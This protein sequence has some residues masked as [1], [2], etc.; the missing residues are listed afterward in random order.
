MKKD[1]LNLFSI[2]LDPA[3]YQKV[4]LIRWKVSTLL[5]WTNKSRYNK[6][7]KWLKFNQCNERTCTRKIGYQFN[8][9]SNVSSLHS[10]K[11]EERERERGIKWILP[12]DFI[13]AS[14]SLKLDVA[15]LSNNYN[16]L[17]FLM[18]LSRALEDLLD[19]VDLTKSPLIYVCFH[20][21]F[22]LG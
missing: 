11:S 12:S 7:P 21:V 18:I 17:F 16:L 3:F 9:H 6:I 4:N 15:L 14:I 8:L 19:L 5:G 20:A 22:R 10:W 2:I 1:Q 13:S